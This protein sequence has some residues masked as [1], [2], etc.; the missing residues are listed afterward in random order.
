[1]IHTFHVGV[2]H[3]VHIS[4]LHVGH[5]GVVHTGHVLHHM[6]LHAH[7]THH[8]AHVG[9]G[10]K[11]FRP[12]RRHSACHTF[13]WCK[14]APHHAGTSHRFRD[15][16]VSFVLTRLHDDIVCF[17]YSNTEFVYLDRL[18]II[19][20]RLDHGHFEPRN[21]HVEIGHRGRVDET[22]SNFLTR[23]EQAGPVLRRALAID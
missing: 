18:N 17:G 11:R 8:T 21:P 20:V 2:I 15:N 10:E 13:S 1:M 23:T 14:S 3:A 7:S 22:Q 4:F 19:P 16:A 5:V 9:H 12:H 6:T